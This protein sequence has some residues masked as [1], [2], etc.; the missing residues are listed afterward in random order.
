MVFYKISEVSKTKLA[1]RCLLHIWSKT[2]ND[3]INKSIYC[4]QGCVLVCWLKPPPALLN[5]LEAIPRHIT[6]IHNISFLVINELPVTV[7]VTVEVIDT[8]KFTTT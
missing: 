5:S 6:V 1:L 8:V 7:T 3:F 2:S 4:I